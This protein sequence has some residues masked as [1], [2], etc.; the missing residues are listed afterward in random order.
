MENQQKETEKEAINNP[1]DFRAGRSPQ[2]DQAQPDEVE[3]TEDE[4][5]FAD[6]AGTQLEQE[7]DE[8]DKDPHETDDARKE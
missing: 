1:E 6:G 8:P 5:E 7:F 3:Y 2:G 4:V